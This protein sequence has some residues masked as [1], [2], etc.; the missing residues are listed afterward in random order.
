[1]FSS[2]NKAGLRGRFSGYLKYKG[3]EDH[4]CGSGGEE[5]RASEE[6]AGAKTIRKSA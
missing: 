5:G 4:E 2:S 3:G 6:I 1:M